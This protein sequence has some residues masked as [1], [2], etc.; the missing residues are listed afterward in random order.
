MKKTARVISLALLAA[1]LVACNPKTYY[2]YKNTRIQSRTFHL[3]VDPVGKNL[4]YQRLMINCRYREPLDKFVK[5]HGIPEFINEYN[6]AARDGIS[7]Y[8][9]V[10]E[11]EEEDDDDC[12]SGDILPSSS[13]YPSGCPRRKV[14]GRRGEHGNRR[15]PVPGVEVEEHYSCQRR[16]KEY[17]KGP[18]P[19]TSPYDQDGSGKCQRR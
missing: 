8:T 14:P 12:Q 10:S 6:V 7:Y 1:A 3:E 19:G 15:Q 16:C 11:V 18:L 5:A 4:G 9:E 2:D 17:D 13:G